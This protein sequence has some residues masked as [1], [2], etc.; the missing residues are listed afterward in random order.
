MKVFRLVASAND[1]NS[2]I[3]KLWIEPPIFNNLRAIV[4]DVGKLTTVDL[5]AVDG[6]G[7]Q[8][9]TVN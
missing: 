4:L 2:A 5:M 9:M 1:C 3:S 6:R 7:N 8:N